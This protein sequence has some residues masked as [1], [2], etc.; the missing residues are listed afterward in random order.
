[1]MYEDTHKN[2]V[3]E[4]E[5]L[6]MCTYMYMYMYMWISVHVCVYISVRVCAEGSDCQG[7]TCTPYHES[8]VGEIKQFHHLL[9]SDTILPLLLPL[10]L[11]S[12]TLHPHTQNKRCAAELSTQTIERELIASPQNNSNEEH[13]AQVCYDVLHNV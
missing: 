12:P 10:L 4:S 2:R 8:K 3:Y 6:R 1:M 9:K 11:F 7:R 5:S 13:A